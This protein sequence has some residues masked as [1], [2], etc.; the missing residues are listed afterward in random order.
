V[1]QANWASKSFRFAAA[2]IVSITLRLS[3]IAASSDRPGLE[4]WE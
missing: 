3:V 4:D 2:I 1:K